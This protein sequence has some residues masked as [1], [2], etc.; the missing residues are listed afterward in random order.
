[1]VPMPILFHYF[2]TKQPS[3]SCDYVAALSIVTVYCNYF[4][5][6]NACTILGGI[7]NVE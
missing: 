7:I 6:A 3:D 1:M 5:G 2:F 4:H